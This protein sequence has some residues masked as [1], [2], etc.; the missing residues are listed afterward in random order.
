MKPRIA[1]FSWT[2]NIHARVNWELHTSCS[3]GSDKH[4]NRSIQNWK[5]TS[6]IFVFLSIQML[7][8]S[9]PPQPPLLQEA[10]KFKKKSII[11]QQSRDWGEMHSGLNNERHSLCHTILILISP[12]RSDLILFF[13]YCLSHLPLSHFLDILRR[14]PESSC[15]RKSSF[16][17][18]W[19]KTNEKTAKII[20][21]RPNLIN[22]IKTD[23]K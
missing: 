19:S 11:C 14:I 20:Q 10:T 17:R 23:R 21:I 5:L 6:E 13:P 16:D 22:F 2:Y 12:E 7:I 3:S 9:F 15:Y 4:V 8:E 1:C 18:T